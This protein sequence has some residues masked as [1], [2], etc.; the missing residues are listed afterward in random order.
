MVV[1]LSLQRKLN[2]LMAQLPHVKVSNVYGPAEVNQCTYKNISK[3]IDENKSVPLGQVWP[4]TQVKVVDEMDQE[5][6]EGEN[7]ELLVASSTLMKGYWNS[8]HLNKLVFYTEDVKGEKL[9]YYRTG[10]LVKRDDKGELIFIGR[11]DRQAKIRGY[12][13]ELREIENF[14][15]LN[16]DINESTVFI[17]DQDGSKSLCVAYTT[18]N[19]QRLDPDELKKAPISTYP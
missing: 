19:Q 16:D 1:N 5:V 15:Y 2:E 12:R 6:P 9:R 10:D 14:L 4:E 7:G 18:R 17:V 13:V 8:P 11:K 3:A